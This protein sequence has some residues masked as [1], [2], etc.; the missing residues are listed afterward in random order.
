MRAVVDGDAKELFTKRTV[1]KNLVVVATGSMLLLGSDDIVLMYQSTLNREGGK[2]V[3]SILVQ[4]F[5]CV[6]V[7]FFLPKYFILRFGCKATMVLGGLNFL[8]FFVTNYYPEYYLLIMSS[9]MVSVGYA[10]FFGA[11]DP[12]INDLAFL[13][14]KLCAG[15]AVKSAGAHASQSADLKEEGVVCTSYRKTDIEKVLCECQK[16]DCIGY[17]CETAKNID[18]IEGIKPCHQ[19]P[20]MFDRECSSGTTQKV[21]QHRYI[22]NTCNCN[23]KHEIYGISENLGYI[24]T[25]NIWKGRPKPNQIEEICKYSDI[26]I[27]DVYSINCNIVNLHIKNSNIV[28][29]IVN[30][31]DI[32]KK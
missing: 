5:F 6:V 26:C 14:D 16:K 15:D 25:E 23:E 30:H 31:G 8:P 7:S 12:Y 22:E 2:G 28:N 13:Y 11:V 1:I 21:R 32:K 4:Y 17:I 24:D 27:K 19:S 3:N 29:Q 10:L 20:F 18:G 9:F